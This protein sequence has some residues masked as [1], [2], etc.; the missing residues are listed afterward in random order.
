MS[1]PFLSD[2]FVGGIALYENNRYN[3]TPV[4]IGTL[5]SASKNQFNDALARGITYITDQNFFD[6]H[7]NSIV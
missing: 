4:H 1:I 7:E 3:Y 6:F 5:R 2:Q